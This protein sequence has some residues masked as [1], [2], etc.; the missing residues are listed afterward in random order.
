[1]KPQPPVDLWERLDAEVS[2]MYA[3]PPEDSFTISTFAEK[4]DKTEMVARRIIEG[5]CR[6]GICEE[7]GRFGS[8]H[9]RHFILRDK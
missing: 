2:A 1:M 6:R 9:A 5:F 4:Y 3:Q 7:I 8:R